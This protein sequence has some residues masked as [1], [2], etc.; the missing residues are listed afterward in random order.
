MAGY[1]EEQ[2][3]NLLADGYLVVHNSLW[4][5]IPKGA[6]IRYYKKGPGSRCERFRPGGFVKC[7][8]TKENKSYMII[9]NQPN[10]NKSNPSYISFTV[11]YDNIEEIW[12]KYD[13]MAFIEIHLIR[14]SLKQKKTQIEELV[15]R[16]NKLERKVAALDNKLYGYTRP[17][18]VQPRDVGRG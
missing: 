12:K 2:I 16:L 6:H 7:H 14:S 3:T 4:D 11:S 1:T 9:E 17:S 8:F 13:R 5:Y 10:G 18:I 15:D